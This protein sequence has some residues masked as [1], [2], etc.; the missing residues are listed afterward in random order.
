MTTLPA[1][2]F[3]DARHSRLVRKLRTRPRSRRRNYRAE[4]PPASTSNPTRYAEVNGEYW[5][6]GPSDTGWRRSEIDWDDYLGWLRER[7][8]AP[9]RAYV[10][11]IGT[12]AY[13]PGIGLAS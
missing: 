10:V 1:I 7:R 9:D 5:V 11:P 3:T 8:V 4:M 6:K 13:R 2:T 12:P